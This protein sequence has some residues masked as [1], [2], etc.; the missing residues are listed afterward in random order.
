MVSCRL[1][2]RR[3]DQR[4]QGS[5]EGVFRGGKLTYQSEAK[6]DTVILLKEPCCKP[7]R[8]LLRFLFF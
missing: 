5:A 6:A 4:A 2:D 8:I 3:P 7:W 1:R